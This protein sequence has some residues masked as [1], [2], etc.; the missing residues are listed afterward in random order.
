MPQSGAASQKV[1]HS[2]GLR[3]RNRHTPAFAV[4]LEDRLAGPEGLR[5]GPTERPV[6]PARRGAIARLRRRLLKVTERLE[7]A[8]A[9]DARIG[10]SSMPVHG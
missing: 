5:C 1:R 6:Q 3:P 10:D 2:R 4:P 7:N 9:A 8:I